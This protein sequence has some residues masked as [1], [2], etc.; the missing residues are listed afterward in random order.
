M[1]PRVFVKG[2]ETVLP[3]T[4]LRQDHFHLIRDL[5]DCSRFL[6]NEVASKMTATLKLFQHAEKQKASSLVWSAA[7]TELNE[8]EETYATFQRF[9]RNKAE[10]ID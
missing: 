1:V 4:A 6:K 9:C 3:K 7:L 8:L 10:V 5:K 2:H